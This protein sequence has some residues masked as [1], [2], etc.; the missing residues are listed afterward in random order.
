MLGLTPDAIAKVLTIYLPLLLAALIVPFLC[1]GVAEELPLSG[2]PIASVKGKGPKLSWLLDGRRL[3]R[4]A[5]KNFSGQPFQVLTAT[6]PK[7][8]LPNKYINELKSHP[9]LN[10]TKS[11]FQD[12]FGHFHGFEPMALGSSGDNTIPNAVRTKM[13]PALGH[14]TEAMAD[15]ATYSLSDICGVINDWKIITPKEMIL[16]IVCRLTS[17][18]LVG[19][20]LCRNEQWL[21]ITQSYTEDLVTATILLRMVPSFIRHVVYWLIPQCWACRRAVQSARKL[22]TLEVK[23]FQRNP[24]KDDKKDIES[25]QGAGTTAWIY[26]ALRGREFDYPCAQLLLTFASV[27]TTTSVL[28]QAI[29]DLCDRP[30]LARKLREEVITMAGSHGSVK[31]TLPNLKLMDSFFKESQRFS[32]FVLTTMHR[33]VEENI[34]LSDGMFLPKGTRIQ[35]MTN[36]DN[37]ETYNKPELFDAERFFKKRQQLGMENSGQ[38][39]TTA[40]DYTLFGHGKHACPGRFMAINAL[41]ILLSHFLL[42]YEW[43]LVH[44]EKLPPPISFDASAVINPSFKIEIRKRTAEIDIDRLWSVRN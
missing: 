44:G 26:N 13:M 17:R 22:I 36:F 32:P 12:F 4:E 43:R 35:F 31:S 28:T 1:R 9:S 11:L 41:K 16:R 27:H 8:I 19:Q 42:K 10:A 20:P 34:T 7:L 5:Q 30:E 33:F 38:F 37:I 6:G 3:V 40:S 39:A 21:A 25:T 29:L 23:R 14:I 2:Y 15:E 18:A 24:N